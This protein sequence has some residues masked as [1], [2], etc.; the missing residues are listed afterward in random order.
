MF[1]SGTENLKSERKHYFRQLEA[2]NTLI[3]RATFSNWSAPH[4]SNLV[5]KYFGRGCKSFVKQTQ[6]KISRY[7]EKNALH[8][9][10]RYSREKIRQGNVG[11]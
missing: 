4:K 3:S 8:A 6:V 5:E 10:F 1:Q 2:A 11:A 7:L 9:V